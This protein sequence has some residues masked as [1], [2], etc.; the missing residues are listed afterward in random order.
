LIPLSFAQTR[1]WFL[2]QLEPQSPAY[3]EPVMS[4]ISGPLNVAAL[5][6]TAREITR[7]HEV[8]R[9]T[10][11]MLDGQVKQFVTPP[12]VIDL[13]E[14]LPL[15]D[16]S[17][18]PAQQQE[19]EVQRRAW[20]ELLRPFE[21]T[22]EYPC[23][24]LLLRLGAEEHVQITI[25]HHIATDGWS[26]ANFF[27]EVNALYE[28]FQAG[29]PSP[30]TP[31]HIQ[32]G[33][34]AY[35]QQQ[36]IARGELDQQIACWKRRLS[37]QIPLLALPTDHPRSMQQ[38]FQ[39]RRVPIQIPP[40]LGKGLQ[41]LNRQEGTTMFI[42]LLAAFQVLLA[43]YSHQEDIVVGTSIAGRMRPE[44]ESLIGC[45][46]NT[47]ALRVEV[48]GHLTF[49]EVLRRVKQVVLEAH[50]NQE[51]PFEKLVEELHPER[52]LSHNPLF[53]V[54]FDWQNTP[55]GVQELAGVLITPLEL[56]GRTAKFDLSLC[57]QEQEQGISGY[58]ECNSAL[59]EHRSVERM[60]G[61]LLVL[62]AAIVTDPDQCVGTLPLLSAQE[63]WQQLRE[64]NSSER[65]YPLEI[66]FDTLFLE[67]VKLTPEAIAVKDERQELSYRELNARAEQLASVLHK[68][69]IGAERIVGVL[70]ERGVELLSCVLGIN[71]AGGA[72]L[73]LDPQWPLRRLSEVLTR[74]RPALSLVARD[75]A[76]RLVQALKEISRE[77]QPQ[78]SILEALMQYPVESESEGRALPGFQHP[79]QMA[80]VIYTSGSTGT[81]KGAMIEQRG[82]L[83]HLCAKVEELELSAADVVAQTAAQSFDISVWQML[84]VLLVGGQ[85]CI[86]PDEV[87]HHPARLLEAIKRDR[88]SVLEVVPSLLQALVEEHAKRELEQLP[89]RWLI[90]TGEAL[91]TE[92]ARRWLQQNPATRL[93]NAYGPTE[94]S[95]DVTHYVVEEV[96][97]G[98]WESLPLGRPIGNVRVYVLDRYLEPVPI[99]VSGEI[100]IGG[101]GVG[102]GYVGEAG[103]TAQ[104][105]LPDPYGG[106]TEGRLYRTGDLGRY[107]A[108]GIVEY[109]GR[110]DHQV[111]V[112]GYRI[113]LTEIE[114]VILNQAGVRACVVQVQRE[115]PA[116]SLLVAYIVPEEGFPFDATEAQRALREGLPEYMVPSAVVQLEAL[117]LTSN[118]KLDRQALP[119]WEG[120]TR[121]EYIAPRTVLEEQL[122]AIWASVLDVERIGIEDNFFALGGH[123]LLIMKVESR[124]RE[125]LQVQLPVRVLFQSS[126]IAELSKEIEQAQA[127]A[128]RVSK[129]ELM[130]LS[131]EAHRQKRTAFVEAFDR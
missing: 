94:C 62:L 48:A 107:R 115:T 56:E 50:D 2:Q 39:G 130:A 13:D 7:R 64:W 54:T 29:L 11:K 8:L 38:G 17:N 33:D 72:Y 126:T 60:A 103:L 21:L 73:P 112:R 19:Q 46:V 87:A 111:K 69:S 51:V 97:P 15:V 93:L 12:E 5:A 35:W 14:P 55:I 16:L 63:R 52:D 104:T 26:M 118:G 82:M 95:D 40:A 127:S 105:Y 4:R 89:L 71:K 10:F 3:N 74:S 47:L 92:I 43:R 125:N 81:P 61:H 20:Q 109:L 76:D 129:P 100:Y 85:L 121:S 75:F 37:G 91:P 131:R 79:A 49:R 44:F 101:I 67:Q 9:S 102:R 98:I 25:M 120:H 68:R 113:E 106:G 41:S 84:A 123:S 65:D 27:H 31:L 108:D 28:A 124:I 30:L 90:A 58:I 57:L 1:L 77:N 83:N 110:V 59:F 78:W 66:R 6:R 34:Y 24:T 45:F 18:L 128:H 99:G 117:P 114:T 119:R 80:Y 122:A 86:Y 53:Q 116:H 70:A 96:E 42:T 36:R 32:Y 88:V 22:H 23:R